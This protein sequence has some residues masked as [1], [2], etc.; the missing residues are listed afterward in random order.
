M[1]VALVFPPLCDPRA[2]QL[3]L[4]SLAAFL[5]KVG[6]E[7]S[8]YDLNLQGITDLF[9]DASLMD[10]RV[11]LSQ[12]AR[13]SPTE[14]VQRAVMVAE[15]LIGSAAD[16][17]TILRDRTA[18]FD[19]MMFAGA[20]RTLDDVLRVHSLAATVVDAGLS[21]IRYRVRGLNAASLK[22]LISASARP[23]TDLFQSSTA[24]LIADLRAL[25]PILVGI[26]I[27][28]RQQI[29]PGLGLA[30][31]L[32][33]AGQF[34]VIGGAVFSKF[35]EQ[36]RV[37]SEFFR[38]F[39]DAVV[40][41][42]G[43]TAL[44]G[45]IDA[46]ASG[47]PL[48]A[49]PNLL[50]SRDSKVVAT[51]T[52][53]EAV[54]LLPTPDFTGL[55]INKYLSP[56]PVLPILT[57]K[58]CYFNRCKFCDIPFINHISKK[59]YRVRPAE[60]VASD[61]HEL[62]LRHGVSHFVITDEALSP[63]LLIELAEAF[64]KRPGAFSFTGY[65]RPE[66]GFTAEACERI[67]RFG[68]RK[69]FFGL[70][71]G[72]QTTLDHMDKGIQISDVPVILANCRQAHIDFHLFGIVGLP[73][74][75]ADEARKTV[76]FLLDNRSVI[77]NPGSSFDVH[78]F[79]LELRTRYFDESEAHGVAIKTG[80]LSREFLIGLE[81]DD[82]INTE[83]LSATE[84]RHLIATEFAPALR[85]A[86]HTWHATPDPIWPPQEEYAVLYA[87]FYKDRPFRW[88]TSM[89]DG[90]L[91]SGQPTRFSFVTSFGYVL[92]RTR[93][94]ASIHNLDY[95]IR[96]PAGLLQMLESDQILAWRDHHRPWSETLHG[97]VNDAEA[98][99][100]VDSMVEL[101][102]LAIH[103]PAADQEADDL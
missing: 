38:V 5:R 21:P 77:D 64:D 83:G 35:R 33:A 69:L 89:P 29:F 31:R 49:V 71:S 70:E 28:N 1:R 50:F 103:V 37:A 14:E 55:P 13:K 11:A 10:A 24:R 42:E 20:R 99:Q 8:L 60:T 27:T 95:S 85:Q 79:G 74:E 90:A 4:P 36:L 58:G 16:S 102:L 76:R 101:G 40:V 98:R 86:F 51:I 80:S 66:R 30:H 53:V 75:T 84:T 19:P 92:D 97:P 44:L 68:M 67:A 2:P 82:W 100:Y 73:K 87:A 45:L 93:S 15:R 47:T 6:I 57:G 56:Y 26:T 63:K 78:P 32:R 72:S 9:D 43:E 54:P 25:D 59:A 65:A 41:Y 12:L 3:A 81:G 34:V 96:L 61:V 91:A 23:E 94:T 17:L 7:V 48:V 18:F 52:H 88:R 62:H 22:D 39:A 46:L